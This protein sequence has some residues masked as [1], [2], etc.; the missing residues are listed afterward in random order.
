MLT[1][2]SLEMQLHLL[3]NVG[4]GSG[5]GLEPLLLVGR[6]DHEGDAGVRARGAVALPRKPNLVAVV[7]VCAR[8]VL[9]ACLA[10]E[11]NVGWVRRDTR[12]FMDGRC[13]MERARVD[14]GVGGGRIGSAPLVVGGFGARG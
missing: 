13:R 4:D 5:G 14:W 3:Q 7:G 2:L 10:K 11:E 6:D 9:S 12:S 8:T 1:S